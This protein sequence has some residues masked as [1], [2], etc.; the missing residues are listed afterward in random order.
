LLINDEL[1]TLQILEQILIKSNI[2]DIDTACNGFQGY[3]MI[4]RKDYDLVISDLNMPV[5]DGFQFCAKTINHY[6]QQIR[7]FD[8]K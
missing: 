5:M 2:K 8:S 3:Q 7:F 4:L 1:F 6:K